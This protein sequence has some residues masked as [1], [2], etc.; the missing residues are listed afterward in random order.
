MQLKNGIGKARMVFL[1]ILLIFPSTP[2]FSHSGG[3][4]AR[5]G[6]VDRNTGT[7]HC[8][9]APC[10]QETASP[11]EAYS[12]AEATLIGVVDGDTIRVDYRGIIEK[13][14]LIGVN[15]PEK[16][17][18]LYEEATLFTARSVGGKALRLEFDRGLR[19]RYGRLLAYVY[20][21]DGAMVNA[22][23]IHHGYSCA[24]TRFPFKYKERFRDIEEEAKGAG[25]TFCVNK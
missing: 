5:G 15:T 21:P 9:R 3:L 14:R 11:D 1:L 23:L 2:A 7:Y 19:D 22:D 24:Y 20:L 10:I 18:S 17:E 16:G 8:H 25:V 6:H 12:N 13:V 4:D